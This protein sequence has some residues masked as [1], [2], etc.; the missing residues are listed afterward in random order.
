M[1]WKWVEKQ[2]MAKE[3]LWK[4]VRKP[5]KPF[6]RPPKKTRQFGFLEAK[7][8]EIGDDSRL[9]YVTVLQIDYLNH[10]TLCWDLTEFYLSRWCSTQQTTELLEIHVFSE[11]T[12]N[13]A[14]ML[15]TNPAPAGLFFFS[16]LFF[17]YIKWVITGRF[18]VMLLKCNI[19][20]TFITASTE[21]I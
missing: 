1:S 15:T 9:S 21:L 6:L 18:P 14:V 17:W 3:K 8:K 12:G 7:Y 2:L 5:G 4:T 11:N 13:K 10:R 19:C 16:F 20:S